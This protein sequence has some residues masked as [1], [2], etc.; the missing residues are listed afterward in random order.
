MLN[1]SQLITHKQ[2]KQYSF[3]AEKQINNQWNN[4]RLSDTT[5]NEKTWESLY[6]DCMLIFFSFS[7][8]FQASFLAKC[9]SRKNKKNDCIKQGTKMGCKYERSLYTFP[10]NSNDAK[11]K[12]LQIKYCEILGKKKVIKEAKRE[13]IHMYICTHQWM[14]VRRNV[15]T[16]LYSVIYHLLILPYFIKNIKLLNSWYT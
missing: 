15:F 3:E 14:Y 11:A 13:H 9:K 5:K 16:V 10:T 8:I 7:N 1:S 12:A 4:H 2:S 6:K